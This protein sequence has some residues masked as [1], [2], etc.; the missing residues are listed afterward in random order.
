MLSGGQVC[1]ILAN[2][3]FREVRR[4]GSHAVMQRAT[5]SGTV[6]V[7]VPLHKQLKTGTLR[8]IVRQS[9]LPRN[10]FESG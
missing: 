7:P 5:D 4:R 10:L 6:T 8:S 2:N 3:G 9:G 1:A